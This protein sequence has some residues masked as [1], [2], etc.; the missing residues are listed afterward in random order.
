VVSGE[1]LTDFT[2]RCAAQIN[3]AYNC[4]SLK[5]F[6]SAAINRARDDQD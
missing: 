5:S 2:H 3:L 6:G 1:V 4:D